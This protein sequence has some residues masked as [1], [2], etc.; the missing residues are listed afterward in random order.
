MSFFT[1][2]ILREYIQFIKDIFIRTSFS[3]LGEDAVIQNH[4]GWL[5]LDFKSKGFY[6]DIGAHH[7]TFGSNTYKFYLSGSSGIC[8]DVGTRKKRIFELL[9]P[10]DT[11]INKAIVPE[12]YSGDVMDFILASND[13]YGSVTGHLKE[14]DSPDFPTKSQI[15][16]CETIKAKELREIAVKM[17]NF[18][19]TNWRFLSMDIE[20]LDYEILVSLDFEFFRFDV[21]AIEEIVEYDPWRKT[22]YYIYESPIVKYLENIGYSLQSIC[23]PTLIFVRKASRIISC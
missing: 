12:S 20:G 5:G 7:P 11:F 6:L 3:Q 18:Q 1:K 15:V 10:R 2:F 22:T 8:I 16:Q 21:V 4:L 17:P 9:R 19:Q 14:K 13:T 23:G